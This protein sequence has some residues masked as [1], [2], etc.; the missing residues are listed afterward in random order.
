MFTEYSYIIPFF[1]TQPYKSVDTLRIFQSKGIQLPADDF[2]L[3]LLEFVKQLELRETHRSQKRQPS[4]GT[5]FNFPPSLRLAYLCC[6]L[7]LFRRIISDVAR[8]Y[9]FLDLTYGPRRRA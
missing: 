8:S 6:S 3:I 7:T 1:L 9:A 5:P 2:S 4:Y